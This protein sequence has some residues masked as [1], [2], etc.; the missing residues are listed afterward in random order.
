MVVFSRTAF[1]MCCHQSALGATPI[2][3]RC[4][5]ALTCVLAFTCVLA[6]TYVL[7]P[8]IV[9]RALHGRQIFVD[10]FDGGVVLQ[11]HGVVDAVNAC[12]VPVELLQLVQPRLGVRADAVVEVVH[13]AL[14][15][16][17]A[18]DVLLAI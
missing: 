15:L 14:L 8:V 12:D 17:A 5:L 7:A 10:G 11:L 6:L 1:E 18:R 9:V 2:P 13:D 16:F 4:V 3:W